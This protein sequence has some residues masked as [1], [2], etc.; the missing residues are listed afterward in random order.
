MEQNG[1]LTRESKLAMPVL[2]VSADQG[3]IRDMAGPLRAFAGSVRGETIAASGHFI[4][5]EQ[6]VVLA[7]LLLDF[8]AAQGERLG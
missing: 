6:S 7:R 8:F 3:S 1:A 5:E 2:A 4:P